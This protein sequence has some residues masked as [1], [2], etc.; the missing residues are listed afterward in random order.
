MNELN[1]HLEMMKILSLCI[2]SE[3]PSELCYNSSLATMLSDP[4]GHSC[5]NV[6]NNFKESRE[7]CNCQTHTDQLYSGSF[8]FLNI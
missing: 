7:N 2:Y 4:R 5:V 6:L 1:V 8:V 3:C